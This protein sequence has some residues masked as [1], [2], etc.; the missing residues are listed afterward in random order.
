MVVFDT[1]TL[2][3]LAKIE[4]LEDICKEVEIWITPEVEKEATRKKE[5]FD[6]R[7]IKRLIQ[8]GKIKIVKI[9][10]EKARK[11]K[12]EFPLGERECTSLVLAWENKTALATDDGPTIKV[13]KICG[14]PFVTAL[15]F[16]L[17]AYEKGLLSKEVALW[18]L[19]RLEKVGRYN[20]TI[21]QRVRSKISEE[22]EK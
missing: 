19:R 22:G 2:I 21:I 17:R 18:K 16:L 1:S 4:L 20:S 13:A 11:L 3:S 15:H 8:E 7:F 10:R 6:A 12:K 5:F 14:I 9:E